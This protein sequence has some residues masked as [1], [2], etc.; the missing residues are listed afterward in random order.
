MALEPLVR[1]NMADQHEVVMSGCLC[2]NI[3][4]DS[5]EACNLPGKVGRFGIQVH[6][7]TVIT[8]EKPLII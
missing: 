5:S 8:P 7:Q 6:S 1:E 4:K 2:H 3:L